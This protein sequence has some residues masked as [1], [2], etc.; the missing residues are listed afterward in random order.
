MAHEFP[1]WDIDILDESSKNTLKQ[2]PLQDWRANVHFL[3][4]TMSLAEL[5]EF[6]RGY[7]LVVGI[8]GGGINIMRSH[9]NSL[10]LFTFGNGVVWGPSLLGRTPT[11]TILSHNWELHLTQIRD[12]RFAGNIYK[13]SIWLPA[14]QIPLSKW[15]VSDFPVSEV[16]RILKS[17]L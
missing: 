12:N 17:R 15:L 5:P 4:N 14:F 16:V 7:R 9:T 1:D 2:L 8:D 3:E 10:T 13:K 11:S 6:A